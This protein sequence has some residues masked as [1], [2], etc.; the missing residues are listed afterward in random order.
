VIR[1]DIGA[2]F[3]SESIWVAKRRLGLAS[4]VSEKEVINDPVHILRP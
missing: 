3:F 2:A 4:L 1:E